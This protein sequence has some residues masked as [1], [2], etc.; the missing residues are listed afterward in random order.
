MRRFEKFVG[1]SLKHLREKMAPAR[2]S[3]ERIQTAAAG[4]GLKVDERK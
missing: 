4:I 1:E 2:A 3:N